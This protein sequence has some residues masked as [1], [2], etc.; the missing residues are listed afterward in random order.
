MKQG[1]ENFS[2]EREVAGAQASDAEDV[3]ARLLL[4]EVEALLRDGQP[5]HAVAH[6][7]DMTGVERE[8]AEAFV[9]ELQ[10]GVFE[11]D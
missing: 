11:Q 1:A 5:R 7:V 8:Q 4:D 6:I 10:N 2:A 9:A 3:A